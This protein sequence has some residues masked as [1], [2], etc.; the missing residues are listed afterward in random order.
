MAIEAI[1]SVLR[2]YPDKPVPIL[3]DLIDF[4]AAEDSVKSDKTF[5]LAVRKD[6]RVNKT[7]I[8]CFFRNIIQSKRG[9]EP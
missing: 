2:V 8:I 6:R 7:N 4:P 1:D 5:A 9:K 3:C